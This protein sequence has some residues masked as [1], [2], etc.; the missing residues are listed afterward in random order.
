MTGR[1]VEQKNA[2]LDQ[3]AL[4]KSFKIKGALLQIKWRR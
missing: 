1:V 3:R 2:A 4:K